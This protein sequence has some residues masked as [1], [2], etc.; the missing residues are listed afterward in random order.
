MAILNGC[1]HYHSVDVL[2]VP[3]PLLNNAM[4]DA[5]DAQICHSA[6]SA[7]VNDL[8]HP[9]CAHECFGIDSIVR[10]HASASPHG[11][12]N[13][14]CTDLEP[15]LQLLELLYCAGGAAVHVLG[16]QASLV[17]GKAQQSF[18]DGVLRQLLAPALAGPPVASLAVAVNLHKR[19][20][21][22]NVVYRTCASA[23]RCRCRLGQCGRGDFRVDGGLIIVSEIVRQTQLS[24]NA[25]AKRRQ[26]KLQ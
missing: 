4:L 14:T 5:G 3:Q 12:P 10:A 22:F 8:M 2:T 21:S 6:G 16:R 24:G 25:R 9:S 7:D 1:F 23:C 19:M 11:A 18:V 20:A 15:R 17:V 13:A 26:R